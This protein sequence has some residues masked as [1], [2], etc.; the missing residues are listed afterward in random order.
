MHPG[1]FT[2]NYGIN[3][4]RLVALLC[5][6]IAGVTGI[7]L[8]AQQTPEDLQ[9]SY[10]VAPEYPPLAKQAM[11]SGD[12]TL[13]ITVD[14]SGKVTHVLAHSPHSLLSGS[15]R[16]V[17]AQWRF[18]P[19]TKVRK[20]TVFFHYGFSGVPRDCNPR[21]VV[22]ADLRTPRVTITVDPLPPFEPDAWPVK[23]RTKNQE[24]PQP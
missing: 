18:V 6:V 8:P 2:I 12:V 13:T 23:K 5:L 3:V 11:Q 21:T 4:S 15:A 17:L 24:P 7:L 22:A 19:G 14:P 9:V 1:T 10:F 16:E 20:G